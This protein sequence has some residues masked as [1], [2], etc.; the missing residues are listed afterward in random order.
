MTDRPKATERVDGGQ[1]H[2]RWVRLA[3]WILAMSLL[4]RNIQNGWAWYTGI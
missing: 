3:H 4:T 2:A 1:G